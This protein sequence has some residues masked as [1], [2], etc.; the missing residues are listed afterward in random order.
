MAA[1]RVGR[2]PGIDRLGRAADRT[3][4]RLEHSFADVQRHVSG[5]GPG[6]AR[7]GPA[8]VRAITC[9]A[10]RRRRA[11]PAAGIAG[12]GTEHEA[13]IYGRNPGR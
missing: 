1:V 12:T 11:E 6:S 7:R 3:R 8:V 13:R 4:H 10:Q 5:G 9:L 2:D